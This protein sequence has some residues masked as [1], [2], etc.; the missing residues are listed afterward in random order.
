MI[1]FSSQPRKQ[2]KQ[3]RAE[4]SHGVHRSLCPDTEACGVS[5]ALSSG[6][7]QHRHNF[8]ATSWTGR[9]QP[10]VE[11]L[12]VVRYT[13]AGFVSVHIA[14]GC[15]KRARILC[16][17][18]S[19]QTE[20][21]NV[22]S[23]A[24]ECRQQF[25]VSPLRWRSLAVAA[26]SLPCSLRPFSLLRSNCLLACIDAH[27]RQ[28]RPVRSLTELPDPRARLAPTSSSDRPRPLALTGTGT[29]TGRLAP[30]AL[31]RRCMHCSCLPP[32]CGSS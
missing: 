10:A 18:D 23:T 3:Q 5:A 8:V 19:R 2:V 4:R 32:A 7:M 29:D 27:A 16:V 31:L 24:A 17:A 28:S 26:I 25:A 22:H 14:S 15:S 6:L 1:N 13:W 30:V 20:P 21:H 9:Q 11:V 12:R